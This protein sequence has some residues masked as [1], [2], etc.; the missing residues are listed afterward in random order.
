[1]IQHKLPDQWSHTSGYHLKAD[2][3]SIEYEHESEP[4]R[5]IIE[6][7]N[8]DNNEVVYYT[9]IFDTST[10][11]YKTVEEHQ[12]FSTVEDGKQHLLKIMARHS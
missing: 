6:S 3:K 12:F 5:A 4:L 2:G 11:P 7:M 10:H 9:V 8:G 1:M